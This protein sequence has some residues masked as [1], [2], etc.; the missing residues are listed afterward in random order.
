MIRKENI[1]NEFEKVFSEDVKYKLYNEPMGLPVRK[2]TLR[3]TKKLIEEQP[4]IFKDLVG[5]GQTIIN[6]FTG[7]LQPVKTE[8]A[9]SQSMILL[10]VAILG[11]IMYNKK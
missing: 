3:K 6:D 4:Q 9:P 8:V 1:N 2:Q 10:A 7:G 5:K 11:C